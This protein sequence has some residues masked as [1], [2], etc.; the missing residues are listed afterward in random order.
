MY[1]FKLKLRKL[2]W[3]KLILFFVSPLWKVCYFWRYCTTRVM[4]RESGWAPVPYSRFQYPLNILSKGRSAHYHMFNGYT[5]ILD[6]PLPKCWEAVELILYLRCFYCCCC[7][8]FFRS[9]IIDVETNITGN[10]LLLP[11]ERATGLAFLQ[12]L[13]QSSALASVACAVRPWHSPGRHLPSYYLAQWV[14]PP[15]YLEYPQISQWQC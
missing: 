10:I 14:S 2:I 12:C 7:F 4:C 15:V 8:V 13:T 5:Q 9:Q 11:V 6:L 3:C 1:K